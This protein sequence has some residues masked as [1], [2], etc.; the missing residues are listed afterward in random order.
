MDNNL[1]AY[2]GVDCAAC[3]DYSGGKCPGCRQTDWSE[4]DACMPIECCRRRAITFCGECPDFP[5]AEMRDFY[6]ESESHARAYD[7]MLPLKQPD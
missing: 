4:G 7:R 5:C 2:C 3:G 1:L 6:Q